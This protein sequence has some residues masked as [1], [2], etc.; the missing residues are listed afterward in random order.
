[1]MTD[2]ERIRIVAQELMVSTRMIEKLADS[3]MLEEGRSVADLIGLGASSGEKT[4]GPAARSSGPGW[5]FW[6]RTRR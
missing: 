6:R 4:S 2:R 3:S 1:M 5:Q